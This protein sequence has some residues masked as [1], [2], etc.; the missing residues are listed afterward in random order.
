M[1]CKTYKRR[2][3]AVHLG[4]FVG[5]ITAVGVL[6]G[7]VFNT[8]SVWNTDLTSSQAAKTAREKARGQLTSLLGA[9]LLSS[10]SALINILG[11][12]NLT[13]SSTFLSLAFGNVVGYM[14]DVTFA[15]DTGL[16]IVQNDGVS[17]GTRY[18]LSQLTTATFGRYIATVLCDVFISGIL[19]A[20]LLT[21]VSDIDEKRLPQL[22][23]LFNCPSVR[24]LVVTE[25]TLLIS[26]I[27]FVVYTNDTRFRWAFRKNTFPETPTEWAIATA[28]NTLLQ[29]LQTRAATYPTDWERFVGVTRAE[30][31]SGMVK[32]VDLSPSTMEEL[33]RVNQKLQR[34]SPVE[35]PTINFVLVSIVAGLLFVTANVKGDSTP[36]NIKLALV[37]SFLVVILALSMTGNL[38]RPERVDPGGTGMQPLY[39]WF[40]FAAITLACHGITLF[41]TRSTKSVLSRRMRGI[42]LLLFTLAYTISTLLP[43]TTSSMPYYAPIIPLVVFLL[44]AATVLVLSSR[45]NGR[46]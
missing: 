33:K 25:I 7:Q 3:L 23:A 18:A 1:T 42:L 24:P 29:D 4:I 41:S 46:N 13:T 44:S 20:E 9:F 43:V 2:I 17:S 30:F 37:L 12:V 15:S 45:K 11:D 40:V 26:M 38:E 28:G 31:A 14:L 36:R 35:T 5:L 6:I 16:R 19:I 21:S 22:H 27:T 10:V 34:R 32:A 8:Q 39:G